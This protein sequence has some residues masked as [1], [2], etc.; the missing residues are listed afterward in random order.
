[1]EYQR[2]HT[3]GTPEGFTLLRH[4][5]L[6]YSHKVMQ[7][8]AILGRVDI[9]AGNKVIGLRPRLIIP[10]PSDGEQEKKPRIF[11]TVVTGAFTAPKVNKPKIGDSPAVEP[12]YIPD[13]PVDVPP[14]PET[15]F[16]I[17]GTGIDVGNGSEP[18][19][20]IRTPDGKTHVA[21][22]PSRT[23]ANW[24]QMSKYRTPHPTVDEIMAAYNAEQARQA[25][26]R[27]AE[28]AAAAAAAAAANN[29][30]SENRGGGGG[31]RTNNDNRNEKR[32]DNGMNEFLSAANAYANQQ[33]RS[34]GRDGGSTGIGDGGGGG[35]SGGDGGGE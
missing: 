12:D 34:E 25:A 6:P 30:N 18:V 20:T 32:N 1:M 24:R 19:V 4:V 31:T 29:S 23:N 9:S 17:I 16:T 21:H 14:E 10:D 8:R 33:S 2:T 5:F 11:P 28:E 27:A 22:D 15:G 3:V 35:D 7:G 13:G 26:I